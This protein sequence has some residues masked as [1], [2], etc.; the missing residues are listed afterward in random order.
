MA[1]RTSKESFLFPASKLIFSIAETLVKKG[2]I[3][4]VSKKGKKGRYV[5]ITLAYEDNLP[6]VNNLKRVSLLSKR[7]YRGAKDI[8]PVRNGVGTAVLSTPKGV[9]SDTE[10][11]T[12]RVGGEVLFEIW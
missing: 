5:E 7:V 11:R 1:S 4:A 12:S 3:K 2:Y 10:A 9:L 8:R 6:K